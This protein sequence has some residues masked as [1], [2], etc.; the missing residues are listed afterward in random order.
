MALV[1]TA[2]A[3]SDKMVHLNLIGWCR[4]KGVNFLRLSGA[5]KILSLSQTRDF[6]K[7]MPAK[8]KKSL[9]LH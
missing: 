8:L 2:T 3:F 6:Q 4:I 9:L 7:M 1:Q 5:K